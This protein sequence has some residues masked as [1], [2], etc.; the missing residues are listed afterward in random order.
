MY[1]TVDTCEEP[2]SLQEVSHS[3]LGTEVGDHGWKYS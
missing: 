2:H 1:Y 3:V